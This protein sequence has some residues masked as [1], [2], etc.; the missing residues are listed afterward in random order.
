VLIQKE[1]KK[2]CVCN[3][4][5]EQKTKTKINCVSFREI[6]NT[7]CSC[8]EEERNCVELLIQKRRIFLSKKKK[9]IFRDIDVRFR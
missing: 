5:E 6:K 1:Q 3:I 2:N 8:R 9:R 7:R 4:E